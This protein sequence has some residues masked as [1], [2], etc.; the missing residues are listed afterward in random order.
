MPALVLLTPP[1]AAQTNLVRNGS[2][3]ATTVPNGQTH[4]VYGPG[5]SWSTIPQ[6][7]AW[8]VTGHSVDVH[9]FT[10][11][12]WTD[13]PDGNNSL[14]LN[15]NDAGGI[16]QDIMTTPGQ[17]Y[18]LRFMANSWNDYPFLVRWGNTTLHSG[19]VTGSP[20]TSPVPNEPG[21]VDFSF[22]NLVA[23]QSMMRLEF[24]TQQ[25]SGAHGL[26]IDNVRVFATVPEP[27]ST[28]LLASG[29]VALGLVHRRR[30]A[31][32]A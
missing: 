31:L 19:R 13:A 4:L 25:Q 16:W 1:M 14:E 32:R 21:W 6:S 10:C 28:A 20:M 7:F 22:T 18:T 2:F 27:A 8:T 9:C 26:S 5:V 29:V 12:G 23:T 11:S 15:G 17:R 3:E 30:R 24:V